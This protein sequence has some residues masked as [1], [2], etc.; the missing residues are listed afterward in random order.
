MEEK[1]DWDNILNKDP[2]KCALSLVCQLAAG[3][4]KE[5]N[6]ANQIYEFIL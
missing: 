2:L 3:A 4:E 6:D 5:N 1:I